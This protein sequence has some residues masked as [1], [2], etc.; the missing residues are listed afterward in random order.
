VWDCVRMILDFMLSKKSRIHQ[1]R[2]VTR[3]T[4]DQL[5]GIG[6]EKDG[7][8]ALG[9]YRYVLSL[10]ALWV[11]NHFLHIPVYRSVT[12]VGAQ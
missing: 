10:L 2:G 3:Y 5:E 6:C 1:S 7:G 9:V 12:S 4:T 11:H 8:K